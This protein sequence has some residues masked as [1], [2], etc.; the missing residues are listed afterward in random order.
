MSRS[1][2]IYV[3]AKAGVI[4]LSRSLAIEF[5]RYG[6]TV[7]V[8]TPGLTLTERINRTARPELIS[9]QR[10]TRCLRRDEQPEDLVGPVFF[11]ASPDAEFIS[12][13]YST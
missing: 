2:Y 6:I 7:N 4:G 10:Q 8:V 11:L 1:K 12:G 5:G 13:Q 3:A 9:Q